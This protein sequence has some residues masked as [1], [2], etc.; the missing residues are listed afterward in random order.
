MRLSRR[1]VLQQAVL[2]AVAAPAASAQTAR[3]REW[4]QP[5]EG[6]HNLFKVDNNLYRS[7][8]FTRADVPAIQRLGIRTV[9][10]L[11]FWH[12]DSDELAGTAIAARTVRIN[13]WSIRDNQVV[14]VLA[15]LG[16]TTDGPFLVHCQHGADRTGLMIAMYRMVRQGWTREA[17]LAELT[18]GGFGYH[19]IWRNIPDYI[20]RVD[21]GAIR[22]QLNG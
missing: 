10:S 22:G 15:V 17:A 1:D 5:V 12:D 13:T 19:F 8:A 16:K 11:R 14:R 7:A 9:V 2:A 18:G 4:A 3:P 20:R 21:V 6:L